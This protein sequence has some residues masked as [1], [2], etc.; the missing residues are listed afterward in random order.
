M[1]VLVL[2]TE[3]VGLL[4]A[5]G[6]PVSVRGPDGQ[7]YGSLDARDAEAITR[8][9]LRNG[10]PRTHWYTHAQVMAQLDA[11]EAERVRVGTLDPA[12][13]ESFI[14]ELQRTD[15]EKYGPTRRAA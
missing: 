6:G 1:P 11:L 2:T 13:L 12:Q 15:P 7:E 4:A 3:Q 10:T 8:H 5:A 14:D 9:R